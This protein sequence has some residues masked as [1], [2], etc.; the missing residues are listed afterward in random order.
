MDARGAPESAA[1]DSGS[2]ANRWKGGPVGNRR[3]RRG[4]RRPRTRDGNDPRI[5]SRGTAERIGAAGSRR[6]GGRERPDAPAS[7]PALA[8][9]QAVRRGPRARG[10]RHGPAAGNA[11]RGDRG[12]RCRAHRGSP[13][14]VAGPLR[15]GSGV[16]RGAGRGRG[17]R[18]RVEP[19]GGA[20]E[21]VARRRGA[22]RNR[23]GGGKTRRRAGPGAACAS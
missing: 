22:G 5:R 15:S 9:A 10:R 6:R 8:V 19:R 7:R 12:A 3:L 11:S 16:H 13:R 1:R 23:L 2:W 20:G 14:G 18:A 21:G 4:S 17:A